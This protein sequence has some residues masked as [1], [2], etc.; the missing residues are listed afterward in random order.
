MKRGQESSFRSQ[1]HIVLSLLGILPLLLIVYIFI[2]EHMNF[3]QAVL[4]VMAIVLCFHLGGFY[5]LRTFSDRL[6]RLVRDIASSSSM[7]KRATLP[8]DDDAIAEIKEISSRFNQLVTELEESKKNFSDVTIALMKYSKE[9]SLNYQSR[10]SE[11]AQREEF[12]APYIGSNVIDQL[13]HRKNVEEIHINN[14][15]EASVLFADIR[16]FT[17]ISESSEPEDVVSMLNEYFESMVEV[18]HLHNG[19]LDK[20]IGDELMAVFGLSPSPN[21]M[22]IDAVNAAIEMQVAL[23]KLMRK[24]RREEKPTFSVGVGINSGT[25]IAGDIGSKKRRDYTVIGDS[26]NVASRLVQIAG[27]GEIL[28]SR[29]TYN[30]CHKAFVTEKKGKIQVRNRREE[31]ECFKIISKVSSV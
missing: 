9:A 6:L 8:E 23:Q 5:L 12:L 14:R 13:I 7:H 28:I 19:I 24:R 3:S 18:I 1:I 27:G 20:F 29:H 16:G 26:V 4:L 21:D 22:A 30:K 10:I 11:S 31:V 17:T 2:H 15:R 25:V